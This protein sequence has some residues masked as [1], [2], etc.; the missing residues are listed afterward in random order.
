MLESIMDVCLLRKEKDLLPSAFYQ[1]KTLHLKRKERNLISRLM[2][3]TIKTLYGLPAWY[4]FSYLCMKLGTFV[5]HD[6][7]GRK[8]KVVLFLEKNIIH[9]VILSGLIENDGYQ[10]TID[11]FNKQHQCFVNPWDSSN[12]STQSVYDMIDDSYA[13][14]ETYTAGITPYLCS[15]AEGIPDV[16]YKKDGLFILGNLSY[17]LSLIH[18]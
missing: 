13:M 1:T 5:L 7:T 14:Y 2:T 6:K 16:N 4:Q 18:I 17:H 10:D 15:L 9:S 11:A 8:R 3:K 12:S